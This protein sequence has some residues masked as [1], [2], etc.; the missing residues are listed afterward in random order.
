[1]SVDNVSQLADTCNRI[2]N[3]CKDGVFKRTKHSTIMEYLG[4]RVDRFRRNGRLQGEEMKEIIAE[5]KGAEEE[6]DNGNAESNA[7]AAEHA[8]VQEAI[9]KGLLQPHGTPPNT[10]QG[11]IFRLLC[12]NPNDLNNWIT[13]N[14][15]LSKAI[16]IKDELEADG[17]LYSEHQLNLRHKDNKN[18]FK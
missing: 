4:K 12:K 1:V 2:R 13:G 8:A 9:T 5:L 14:H 16:E 6:R 11:G 3:I 18:D 15:K 10:K 7:R 17:L